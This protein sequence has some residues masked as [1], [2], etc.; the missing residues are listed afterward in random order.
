MSESS[1]SR[2][3]A[4]AGYRSCAYS[5]RCSEDGRDIERKNDA[6]EDNM[7]PTRQLA[8]SRATRKDGWYD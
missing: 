8:T 2:D 3:R 6:F 5:A 7:M 1:A 4:A